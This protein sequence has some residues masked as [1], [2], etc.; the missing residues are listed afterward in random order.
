MI[1]SVAIL[2]ACIDAKHALFDHTTSFNFQYE[3]INTLIRSMQQLHITPTTQISSS[4]QTMANRTVEYF[5]QCPDSFPSKFDRMFWSLEHHCI[6]MLIYWLSDTFESFS[7]LFQAIGT[8]SLYFHPVFQ[9]CLILSSLLKKDIGFIKK[10]LSLMGLKLGWASDN[11]NSLIIAIED[12]DIVLLQTAINSTEKELLRQGWNM[13]WAHA[14]Y[15]TRSDAMNI[16]LSVPG[17]SPDFLFRSLFGL[18][19]CYEWQRLRKAWSFLRSRIESLRDRSHSSPNFSR[20]RMNLSI[21]QNCN[22]IIYQGSPQDLETF[23]DIMKVFRANF[24]PFSFSNFDKL[25][26]QLAILPALAS[27]KLFILKLLSRTCA[28]PVS[29]KLFFS[30]EGISF[31]NR[32]YQDGLQ[33]LDTFDWPL[34]LAIFLLLDVEFIRYLCHNGAYLEKR[35]GGTAFDE[36]DIL[37]NLRLT[38]TI[39]D[40][41]KQSCYFKGECYK[42]CFMRNI[43]GSGSDLRHIFRK[44][45]KLLSNI[46]MTTCR[47][48]FENDCRDLY[49]ITGVSSELTWPGIQKQ[50]YSGYLQD[51]TI[52]KAASWPAPLLTQDSWDVWRLNVIDILEKAHQVPLEASKHDF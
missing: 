46:W 14:Q 31:G 22:E 8:H 7:D 20:S 6:W 9:G 41:R 30:K 51:V 40:A 27:R 3:K 10:F 12:D 33:L 15:H 11:L 2:H 39:A 36:P 37:R 21:L 43:D 45:S 5:K 35:E 49:D 17:V 52:K 44:T 50:L 26:T 24:E 25:D 23:L 48:I 34:N 13:L 32:G 42:F 4:L 19:S 47:I 1:Y 38:T 29:S 16:L 28:V 18:A